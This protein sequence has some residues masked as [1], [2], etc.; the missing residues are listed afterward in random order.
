MVIILCLFIVGCHI[1]SPRTGFFPPRAFYFP[2]NKY[3]D[4]E[5][6]KKTNDR[7]TKYLT[8]DLT[9]MQEPSLYELSNNAQARTYRFLWLRS[10]HRHIGLRLDIE[11]TGE[12]LLIVKALDN[13]RQNPEDVGKLVENRTIQISR[14][15]VKLFLSHLERARFWEL[16][17]YDGSTQLDGS[18]WI[19]EG[20]SEDKYHI[21]MQLTPTN[22]EFKESALFLLEKSGLKS[23][24]VY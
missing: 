12:A 11:K 14:E 17:T 10:F 6:V 19:I 8:T 22:G 15:E 16:V 1:L 9:A 24:K 13:R 2:P 4:E 18:L 21:V 20:V 7:L 5:Y 23:E 3:F